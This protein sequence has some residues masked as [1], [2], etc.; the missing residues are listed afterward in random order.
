MP[1]PWLSDPHNF[2][3]NPRN[4]SLLLRLL[5]IPFVNPGLLE[6][7]VKGAVGRSFLCIGTTTHFLA[8]LMN[9][10][11]MRS[12]AAVQDKT[13]AAFSGF[14]VTSRSHEVVLCEKG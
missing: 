8:G 10:D 7:S 3:N 5:Q 14:A 13:V 11:V 9:E 12:L 2:A 4:S 1:R 6:D